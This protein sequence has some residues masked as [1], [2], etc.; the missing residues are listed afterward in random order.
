MEVATKTRNMGRTFKP[1]GY[2]GKRVRAPQN[3]AAEKLSTEAKQ[4]PPGESR[5]RVQNQTREWKASTPSQKEADK[6]YTSMQPQPLMMKTR[7]QRQ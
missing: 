5:A 3:P 7:L 1:L 2:R 6:V 4:K